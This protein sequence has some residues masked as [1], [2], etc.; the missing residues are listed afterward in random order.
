MK[1]LANAMTAEIRYDR[2]AMLMRMIAAGRTDIAEEMPGLYRLNAQFHT[3][4][5]H[6]DQLLCLR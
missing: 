4:F 5:R 1:F 6:T 2:I 3:L